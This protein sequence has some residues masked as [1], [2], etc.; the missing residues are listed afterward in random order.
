MRLLVLLLALLAFTGEASAH[1]TSLSYVSVEDKDG[2]LA[3][4]VKMSFL[5]LE[6]SAGV[7]Q[8]FDGR[9]TW[10]EAKGAVSRVAAYVQSHMAMSAGGPCVLRQT[11]AAPEMLNG[12]GYL[13][14]GFDVSC[15]GKA[16][17]VAVAS[18]IFLEIDPTSRVLVSSRTGRQAQSYVLGIDQQRAAEA[19]LGAQAAASQ[20]AG[21]PP[22]SLLS[23]FWEGVSH[24]FGG[25]DHMLFLLV[26]VIPAIYAGNGIRSVAIAVLLP[27]TGFTLGHALTLTS[28][29]SG[30][31]RPPAQIV[32][33]LI[34]VTIL[35]TAIDNIRTFIPGPRSVV[36]FAFGLI[37]GFGFAS[38][39]GALEVSGWQ[40]AVALLGFNLGIEAGQAML[41]L[42]VAPALFLVRK[43]ARRLHILPT[44]VSVLAGLMA[45]W[46]IIERTVLV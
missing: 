31:I 42:A 41:A 27:V 5:D 28:A 14:L 9:I 3:A 45:V 24:L 18:T 13:D 12:E 11:S 40:M 26:L 29:A 39:L 23:Y 37:H 44:G 19:A 46:W 21:K 10:G 8:D 34:A 22:A 6:V 30:L 38:A 25:P 4:S 32:E 2:A 43:P 16:A 20:P 1:Q 17:A 35:L 15:P 36:A 33:V 7:D